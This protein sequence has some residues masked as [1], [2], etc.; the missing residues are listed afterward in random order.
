[1]MRTSLTRV[2]KEDFIP[3][4]K[5]AFFQVFGQKNIRSGFRGAGLVS[6]DLEQVIAKLDV[7]LRTLTPDIE[8]LSLPEPW[9]SQT[10]H[11]PIEARSQSIFLKDR[12]AKHQGSSPIFIYAAIDHLEKGTK[13]IMH[14]L[15]L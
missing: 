2:F 15:A 10:S 5:D 4:F 8:S 14:K 1:M 6:H 13:M 11:N 3:A 9:V 7:K 12:I